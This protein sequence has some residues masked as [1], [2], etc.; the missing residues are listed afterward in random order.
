MST[1]SPFPPAPSL[2][3]ITRIVCEVGAIVSLG[4]RRCGERRFVP[5]G[6]GSAVGPALHGT[7]VEG[8]VTG[9]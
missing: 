4:H 8:G 9:S 3:P 1:T 5:L 2:V 7:L 6:G